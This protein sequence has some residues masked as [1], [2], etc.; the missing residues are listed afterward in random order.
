MRV[1][2]AAAGFSGFGLVAFSASLA[3]AQ[4]VPAPALDA[5]PVPLAGPPPN[6]PPRQLQPE[7]DPSSDPAMSNARAPA[8]APGLSKVQRTCARLHP[9]YDPATQSYPDPQGR[10]RACG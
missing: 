4:A 7:F 5:P 3:I 2:V 6:Q 8:I 1:S 10:R 9:G